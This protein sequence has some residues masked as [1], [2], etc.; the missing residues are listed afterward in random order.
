MK[1]DDPIELVV[2]EQKVDELLYGGFVPPADKSKMSMI[3][4]T[5][6]ERLAELDP[7]FT[8]QRLSKLLPLY[9]ARNYPTSLT[10]QQQ[11]WWENFRATRLLA[12]GS[13]SR[14]T[15]YFKRLE[16]LGSR[17]GLSGQDK[18]LLEELKLYGQ[19]VIPDL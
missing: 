1:K 10:D 4:A 9:K 18:Y 3:R 12:G 7:G 8:D 5:S 13:S 14:A 15:L 19:A 2:D 11:L 6:V 16:E 17:T